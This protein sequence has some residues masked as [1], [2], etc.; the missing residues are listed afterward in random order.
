M[1]GAT[2]AY[3]SDCT[4]AGPSR[5][6]LFAQFNGVFYVGFSVGPAIGAWLMRH[7][8][9]DWGGH[10]QLNVAGRGDVTSVFAFAAAC[11]LLNLLLVLFV[12]PESLHSKTGSPAPAPTVIAGASSSSN[13]E[14]AG[15]G[16]S[17][18]T[19]TTAIPKERQS[20]WTEFT[21]GFSHA[22]RIF[23]PRRRTLPGGRV[24]TDRS[25]PLLASS[26]F[27]Y[28]LGAGIFQIK[29]LYAQH[30][31]GWGGEELSLY[32]FLVGNMRAVTLL[33]LVPSEYFLYTFC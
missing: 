1:Q 10:K 7:P 25:L 21:S 2:S 8:I 31:F 24:V 18:E 28:L 15:D 17:S 4:S 30:V 23:R 5:A 13:A 29:Y 6:Q 27:L 3:L 19:T 33:V 9:V 16:T 11:S 22:I 32:I 26:L 14:A 12:F 20:A